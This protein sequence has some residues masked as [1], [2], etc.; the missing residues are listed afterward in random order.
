MRKEKNC[1][2][3]EENN[4]TSLYFTSPK[5][6]LLEMTQK[7]KDFGSSLFCITTK[8]RLIMVESAQL[9]AYK[10]NVAW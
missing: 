7:M 5:R 1:V 8:T 9:G 4:V 10:Q 3:K 2:A 6:Q